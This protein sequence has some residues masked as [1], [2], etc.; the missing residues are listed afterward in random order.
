MVKPYIHIHC[1]VYTEGAAHA[2]VTCTPICMYRER[3]QRS[4]KAVVKLCIH[5]HRYV[6]TEREVCAV[7]KQVYGPIC[8]YA[9]MYMQRERPTQ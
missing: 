7:V 9:T 1:Y 8:I 6:Y 2:V 4:S 5:I 3:G